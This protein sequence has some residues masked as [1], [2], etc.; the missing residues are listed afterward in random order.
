MDFNAIE[1]ALLSSMVAVMEALNVKSSKA[2]TFF[3]LATAMAEDRR[4][5]VTSLF[6]KFN[7][8]VPHE[9]E[10]WLKWQSQP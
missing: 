9:L 6:D 7:K 5:E 8:L 10:E 3:T 2:I 1:F 4:E